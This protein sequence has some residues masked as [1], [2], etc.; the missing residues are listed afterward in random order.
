[1]SPDRSTGFCAQIRG[2]G[3]A[4]VTV[5]TAPTR[6]GAAR[7][8]ARAYADAAAMGLPRPVQVRVVAPPTAGAAR[9]TG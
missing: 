2:E 9:Q 4:W 3:L 8:A 6:A 5:G 1:M 7:K